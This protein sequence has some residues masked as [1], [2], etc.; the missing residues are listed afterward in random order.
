M[1]YVYTKNKKYNGIQCD[2]IIIEQLYQNIAIESWTPLVYCIKTLLYLMMIL[3]SV[4]N[5]GSF[6]SDSEICVTLI[7]WGNRRC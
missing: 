6:A 1:I 7:L 4:L 2:L 5:Q 3:Y